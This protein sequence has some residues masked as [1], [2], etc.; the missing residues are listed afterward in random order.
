LTLADPATFIAPI[1]NGNGKGWTTNV[2]E[3][4][5]SG[6]PL[7]DLAITFAVP[8]FTDAFGGNFILHG[9][10]SAGKKGVKETIEET[11]KKA[12]P[13]ITKRVLPSP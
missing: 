2:I 12:L 4:N 10:K 13:K 9:A 7:L 1:F 5:G 6:N 11:G 3:A 8:D